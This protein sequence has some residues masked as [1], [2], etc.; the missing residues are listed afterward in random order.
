[1]KYSYILLFLAAC[2][3]PSDE[4]ARIEPA[5]ELDVQL[6]ELNRDL[7]RMVD[8]VVRADKYEFEGDVL[9]LN[10]TYLKFVPKDVDV[11][12]W[13]SRT[14][15]AEAT[16]VCGNPVGRKA[17]LAGAMYGYRFRDE[18]GHVLMSFLIDKSDCQLN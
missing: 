10:L 15:P 6:E 9:F 11:E 2:N 12:D 14:K 13:I 8:D 16:R 3:T 18:S 5:A 1:M 4:T 7:P 17:I